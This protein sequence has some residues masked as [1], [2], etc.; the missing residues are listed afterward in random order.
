MATSA[1]VAPRFPARPARRRAVLI[2]AYI[3]LAL[4]PLF[5][6]LIDLNPGR[7]FVINVSVMIGFVALAM[8]GLQFVLVARIR[9]ISRPFGIDRLLQFHRQIT[10]VVLAFVL[11]HP[12]LLFIYDQ[13]FLKLLDVTT[14]PLRA[15]MAVLSVI[16]LLVLIAL[17]VW[18]TRIKLSYERWQLTHGILAIIICA[19]ALTHAL[20][21][22]YYTDEPWEKVLW[23][24]MSFAFI[25]LLLWVRV[26]KP[27]RRARTGWRI[28]EIRPERG[29]ATSVV[30]HPQREGVRE[31]FG[32][33]PG[34]FAWLMVDQSPFAVTQHPF[35]L[36]SSCANSEEVVF[37]IKSLGDFTTGIQELQTGMT[38]YLD[39]PYG[40]FSTFRYP[41]A[42]GYVLIGA[43]VGIT[44]LMS[45]L[46]TGVDRGES[47][48]FQLI[49]GSRDWES[50]T[51][52]D[53][54]E[55]IGRQDHVEVIHVLEEPPEDWDGERGYID[56]GVFRRH[57]PEDYMERHYFICGPDPMMDAA[58]RALFAIGVPG[59]QI[60]V[61]RFMMA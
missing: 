9:P 30:L 29:A 61:E 51:F 10:F 2:S 59:V 48:P 27:L 16:A 53:E 35:S 33:E 18:R 42:P 24:L 4:A 52:R 38:V 22:G 13:K 19:A 15:R 41:D 3:A 58:E 39:G 1:P 45:I 60:H 49:Y 7:G 5:L 31:A 8:L 40:S 34:M 47:V 26:V 20:L 17:S 11:L 32:F 46:R 36:S 14:A 12:L 50:I 6:T 21:V 43:G 37:T 57:L 44:P 56:E 23:G 55:V 54:L 28:E 25:S